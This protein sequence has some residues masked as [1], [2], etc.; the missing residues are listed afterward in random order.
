MTIFKLVTISLYAIVATFVL[1]FGIMHLYY[2]PTN[3]VL[4][5]LSLVEIGIG[6]FLI[7]DCFEFMEKQ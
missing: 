1:A 6:M 2:W 3:D 4:S 7:K 5:Q